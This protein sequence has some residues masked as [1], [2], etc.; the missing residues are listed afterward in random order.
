FRIHTMFYVSVWISPAKLRPI[1]FFCAPFFRF[2]TDLFAVG[3]LG[4]PWSRCSSVSP[5]VVAR[6]IPGHVWPNRPGPRPGWGERYLRA[7][8]PLPGSRHVRRD[9]AGALPYEIPR[10][11]RGS[12]AGKLERYV[13]KEELLG[14]NDPRVPRILL[15]GGPRSSGRTAGTAL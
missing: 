14:R 5:L 2:C 7:K 11:E 9:R 6:P 4:L 10:Q 1:E 15:R 3:I 8:R 12:C 13:R